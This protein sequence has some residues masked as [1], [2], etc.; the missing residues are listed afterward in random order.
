MQVENASNLFV[1]T[2]N[3][4]SSKYFRPIDSYI[5]KIAKGE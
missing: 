1:L 5:F 4:C 3:V 2:D